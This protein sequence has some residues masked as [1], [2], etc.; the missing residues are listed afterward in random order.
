[1]NRYNKAKDFYEKAGFIIKETADIE[2]GG[3][4]FMNDYVMELPITAKVN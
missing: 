1:V 4:F 2:I 3:G